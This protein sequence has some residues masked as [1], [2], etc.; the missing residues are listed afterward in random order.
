MEEAINFGGSLKP[1]AV[2]Q[3]SSGFRAVDHHWNK[4]LF[5]TA[6]IKVD[7]W[8]STRNEPVNS[9]AWGT[10]S[11]YSCKFNPSETDVFATT[12]SDRSICL[13]DLR[14]SSPLRKLIM[15]T[16]TNKI[17]WNP[18]EAFN[19]TA[20]SEDSCCY[21]YD[22][23]K[24]DGATCIH[25]DHVSAVMDI[26]YSPTGREFVTGSYDR[27][28]RIF[29]YN[30]GRSR[31]VYH[32]KRMQRVFSVCYSQDAAYVISGSD[33]TIIR[34]WKSDASSQHGQMLNREKHKQAH[35]NA[36]KKRFKHLPEISRIERH[37]HVPKQI[38]RAS[39]LRTTMEQAARV[40]SQRR[41]AH[42]TPEAAAKAIKSARK[43]KIVAEME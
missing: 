12:A 5:V 38:H 1:S 41:A 40:K 19:F 25:K 11:V 33:D 20:A 16:K 21:S 34:L 22:M 17:A 35:K 28:I 18:R 13:Y 37:H 24:M 43:K 10:D 4:P 23:R 36:V 14:M 26:D 2:F 27:T 8:D 30:A 7:V 39:K 32:T 15:Q 3:G 29:K 9:F 42:S 31:D 6:G